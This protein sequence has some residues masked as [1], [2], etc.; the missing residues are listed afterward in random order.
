MDMARRLLAVLGL[1]VAAGSWCGIAE[2]GFAVDPLSGAAT[3]SQPTFTAFLEPQDQ[4]LARVWVSADTQMD[5][6]YMP[7]HTLGS[8]IP[9]IPTVT[10]YTFSCQPSDYST[11]GGGA[12]LPP[13]TYYWWLTFYHADPDSSAS[14]LRISGPL[15]FTVPAPVQVEPAGA[16]PLSPRASAGSHSLADAPS[17]ARAARYTGASIKETHLTAAVYTLTKFLRLPKSI[18]VA[19]WSERDWHTVNSDIGYIDAG[20]S[21]LGFYTDLMPHWVELSPQVCRALETLLHHRPQYP[22]R[23]TANAVETLA[24]EMMHALGINRVRYG[25]L[26]EPMAE[27]YGMQ[28]S[29]IL[30]TDLGVPYAY[31]DRL[32][33]YNLA[34]YAL[35]PA[36]Y[37]DTS[38]CRENGAWDLYKNWNSPPWNTLRT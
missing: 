8:C 29:V 27:C 31:A 21:L 28:L 32:A 17:L 20:Y 23:F 34:N 38:R 18:A 37:R 30:A 6:T 3:T 7:T 9:S 25:N 33:K 5:G 16:A 15:V 14:T 11:A 4:P 22:N 13:G 2:A 26:A 19:C 10:Q 24:H 1:A 35:R 36:G 12:S